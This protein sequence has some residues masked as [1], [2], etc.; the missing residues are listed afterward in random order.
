MAASKSIDKSKAV[1]ISKATKQKASVWS[2]LYKFGSTLLEYI[3]YAM[4]LFVSSM[5]VQW[6]HSVLLGLLTFVILVA[7]DVKIC[8]MLFPSDEE[9]IEIMTTLELKDAPKQQW[10]KDAAAKTAQIMGVVNI[11][12]MLGIHFLMTH[13]VVSC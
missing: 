12:L 11:V 10:Y 7:A 5:V 3:N 13:Q 2:R 1:P 4:F 6:Q 8:L 9:L